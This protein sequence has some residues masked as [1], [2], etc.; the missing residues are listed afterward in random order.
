MG[1]NIRTKGQEGE[2]EVAR[3][4]NSIVESVLQ[5]HEIKIPEK[6]IVQ[7]NQNQSAVGGSDLQNPFRLAVEVK[8]QE[9]LSINTWWKQC[10]TSAIADGAIPVL[11]FRQNGNR[12][13]RCILRVDVPLGDGVHV[14]GIR[15]EISWDDFLQWFYTYVDNMVRRGD[16]YPADN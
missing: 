3:A 2:R 6:P 10:C 16:W 15:A 13:W 7:R 5:K 12:S 9:A 1:I 4:M 14:T 8:R 11:L